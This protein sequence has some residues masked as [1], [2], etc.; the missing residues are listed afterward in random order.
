MNPTSSRSLSRVRKHLHLPVLTS[1]LLSLAALPAPAFAADPV[2]YVPDTSLLQDS[3]SRSVQD[4]WGKS[5]NGTGY[6]TSWLPSLAVA[7]GAGTVKMTDPGTSRTLEAGITPAADLSASYDVSV[8]E[9]PRSGGGIHTGLQVR[10]KSGSFY[11]A[12]LRVLP[13]G[14]AFLDISRT[15]DGPETKSALARSVALP[16]RV[17]AG[18]KVNVELQATGSSPVEVKARAWLAGTAPG[19]WQQTASDS[20]GARITAAGTLRITTYVS[21]ASQP[22]TVAYDDLAAQMLRKATGPA[23][24]PPVSPVEPPVTPAPPVAPDTPVAAGSAPVGGTAYAIPD[25]AVF[26]APGGSDSAAGTLAAPLRTIGAAIARAS[27]GGS[28]VLRGGSY[29]EEVLIPDNKTLTVQAY[30]NEAVWIDGS[31][32]VSNFAAAAK[33]FAASNWTPAFDSSSTYQWGEPGTEH[34]G[35]FVDPAHPMA[36]HPDQVWIDNVAQRQ[37]ASLAQVTAGTFFVDYGAKKLYIGTNPAGKTVRASAL[38]K[39]MSIRANNSVIRGIGIRRFAPSVPHMGAVTVERPGVVMENVAITDNATTG[40]AVGAVDVTLRN[41]SATRNGLMGASA[42]YADRLKVIGLDASSNNVE[43][44][45]PA[46]VAGGMKITR[47]RGV[48]VNQS[49]FRDNLATGLWLD[50][51]VYDTT[52]IGN[53]ITA[54]TSHGISAEISARVRMVD[55]VVANNRSFGVKVNN[56]SDVEI[57]NNTFSG[58]GRQINIVQDLRRASNRATPGHDPRQAFPDKNMTWINGPVT[59]RNNIIAATSSAGNCMLCVEDYS[60]QFSAEQL[61]VTAEGNVYHRATAQSP[62]WAVVWSRGGG[63]PSVFTSITAF[64]KGTGHEKRHLELTGASPLAPVTFV[65]NRSV[66]D[67]AGAV[68]VPLPVS[69]AGLAGQPSGARHLGAFTN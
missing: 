9:L 60:K 30:P 37:V 41:I 59:V 23:V 27:Q 25:R 11:Q 38:A 33:A 61:Q 14:E 56:T 20:A 3:M 1:L 57:W 4:G 16:F 12:T 29:H 5:E 10:Y 19:D 49:T 50:E 44:F 65:A 45:K 48:A 46:P 42:V 34:G 53:E 26:A 24:P 13:G 17:G 31:R 67:Q 21:T 8:P 55:N 64:R 6:T 52:I 69:I 51:S 32:Q 58:N 2:E 54:N 68:A 47:T 66:Q 43:R 40:I 62:V 36:A 7:D 15:N 35:S 22:V 18:Q 39:A 28:I 63:N